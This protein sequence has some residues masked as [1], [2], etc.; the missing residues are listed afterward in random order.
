MVPLPMSV[1][2]WALPGWEVG[3]GIIAFRGMVND[4]RGRSMP[5]S[6]VRQ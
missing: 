4:W 3:P 1:P 5:S 6:L 2:G